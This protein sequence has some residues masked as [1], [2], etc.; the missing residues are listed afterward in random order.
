MSRVI[1]VVQV[2]KPDVEG[3]LDKL[4]A[5]V[6]HRRPLQQ[7]E[8]T[9]LMGL[10]TRSDDT[11]IGAARNCFKGALHSVGTLSSLKAEV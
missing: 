3:V 4:E 11:W 10:K 1:L 5:N 9:K 6:K 8:Q 2:L 7:E